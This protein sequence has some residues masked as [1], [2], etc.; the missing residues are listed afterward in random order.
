[1]T[2]QARSKLE[3]KPPL[4]ESRYLCVQGR[5]SQYFPAPTLM[6]DACLLGRDCRHEWTAATVA[7]SFIRA[8]LY[9]EVVFLC[10]IWKGT[11]EQLSGKNQDATPHPRGVLSRLPP[12]QALCIRTETKNLHQNRLR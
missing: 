5:T 10:R 4:D 2:V 6:T 3:P 12:Q 9:A 11:R 8:K 1:M 7:Y